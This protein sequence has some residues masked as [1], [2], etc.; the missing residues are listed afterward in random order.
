M[1]GYVELFLNKVI[2]FVYSYKCLKFMS[3]WND[4]LDWIMLKLDLIL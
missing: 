4:C 2:K 3:F 1:K